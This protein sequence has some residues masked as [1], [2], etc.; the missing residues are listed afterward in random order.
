[1]RESQPWSIYYV[2]ERFQSKNMHYQLQLWMKL[3]E[4]VES[5]THGEL[6]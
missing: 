3:S 1:M 4:C 6:V 2:R 5:R